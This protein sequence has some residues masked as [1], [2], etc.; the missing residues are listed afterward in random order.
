MGSLD[1]YFIK[2][3]DRLAYIELRED[4]LN[5]ELKVTCLDTFFHIF[6]IYR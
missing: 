4:S 5:E 2:Y 1:G 6:H 3:T